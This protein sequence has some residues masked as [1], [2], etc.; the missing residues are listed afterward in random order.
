MSTIEFSKEEIEII[1]CLV[2]DA[3]DNG[4]LDD[5][6]EENWMAFNTVFQ[7]LGLGHIGFNME[8]DE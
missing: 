2:E 3:V 4:Y 1:V 7:K 8:E 6:P 5:V